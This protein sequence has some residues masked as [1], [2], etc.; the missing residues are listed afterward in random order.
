M[1]RWVVSEL[2]DLM[3]NRPLDLQEARM[4]AERQALRF[5]ALRGVD[6]PCLPEQAIS[7]LPRIEVRRFRHW[8]SSGATKWINGRWVIVIKSSEPAG[9][10]KLSLA[11]ELKHILDHPFEPTIYSR[12]PAD[13]RAWFVERQVCD[14]FAGCLLMPRPWL[15]RA[16][17][18]RTQRLDRLA[19]MF[20]VTEAAMAT[21]LAQIGL[22]APAERCAPTA[23]EQITR[24]LFGQ[25][26]RYR[27]R[28]HPQFGASPTDEAALLT[29]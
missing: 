5:L 14:Y 17:T 28:L 26:V 8:P 22:V 25:N 6:Y 23:N 12:V 7:D 24:R 21:R 18:T 29:L 2:R 11:H 4:I 13:R 27:R 15:K 20:E 10:Q 16:Y 9:R 1:S 3:P 19:A